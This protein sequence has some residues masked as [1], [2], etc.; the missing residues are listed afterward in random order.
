M[1]YTYA[2]NCLILGRCRTSAVR[3]RTRGLRSAPSRCRPQVV[4]QMS[5]SSWV[6]MWPPGPVS[7]LK[8]AV[9][10]LAHDR[11]LWPA[12]W[13][14]PAALLFLVTELD[15]RTG[16]ADHSGQH[17][18]VAEPY[19]LRPPSGHHRPSGS[20]DGPQRPLPLSIIDLAYAYSFC[21]QQSLTVTRPRP[22]SGRCHVTAGRTLPDSAL[23]L[24]HS[25]SCIVRLSAG[26]FGA[27]TAS[28]AP[29]TAEELRGAGLR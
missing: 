4:T 5:Y 18:I 14:W 24:N 6:S 12:E 8:L 3:D 26:K 23:D 7:L 27:M 29:T 28:Q 2:L 19:H 1:S 13:R 11:R 22:P 9:D 25:F 17:G 10:D 21:H 16:G 20:A 15:R